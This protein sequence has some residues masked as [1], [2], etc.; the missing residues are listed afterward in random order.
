MTQMPT[1]I[2]NLRDTALAESSSCYNV[3]DHLK[4]LTVSE[5]QEKSLQDRLPWHT[6]CL[7][8][9]G[10]LNVGTI[11]RT[12]HCLGAASV[13]IF[14]RQRIDN[15][16]LVGS[17][18]YIKVDKILG[19]DANFNFD[20]NTLLS[21]LHTHRLVPIF[22]ECGGQPLH[23]VNWAM[24][25]SE[26][27]RRNMQP[28]LIMGNETGGIPQNILDLESV[29]PNSFTVSVPQRGVIRSFN[30]ATAHAMISMKLCEDMKW[31]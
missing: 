1:S 16:S 26:M 24:R 14:G 10:D 4:N 6:L 31:L 30:V 19:V 20:S 2:K 9:T 23:K 29:I 12:S 28:C 25:V 27:Q 15:R 11:I 8:V 5:L 21:Y 18:N 13:T 22:V 3:H 7:N 17:A